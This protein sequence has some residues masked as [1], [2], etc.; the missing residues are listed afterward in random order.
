[1]DEGTRRGM[2]WSQFDMQA[3][4]GGEGNSEALRDYLL[5]HFRAVYS[6]YGVT[7]VEIGLAA[8]T[9]VCIALRRLAKERPDVAQ[10]LF[11]ESDRSP[12]VFQ[13][14]PF[15]H[16]I[17]TNAQRELLFTVTR[18][19]TLLP[20]IRYNPHDEGGVLRDDELRARL[21][22]LDI[23]LDDLLPEGRRRLIRMPYL[24]VFGRKDGTVSVM[25]ANIYPEDIEAAIYTDAAVASRILSWQLSV[26][27]E[28]PGETRPRVAIQF[29]RDD[30]SDDFRAQLATLLTDHL[31]RTN[32]DYREA[33]GEYPALLPVVVD[34][35]RRGE[36]PFEGTE[37]RIKFKYVAKA[38]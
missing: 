24:Y 14:N 23:Q 2:D 17:A 13:Y 12:M 5:R 6:G 25:G 8:E 9:P 20:K 32:R 37:S 10:A 1:M 21:A 29:L 7:D 4:L 15:F 38:P 22:T 31:R 33:F 28:R 34:L 11:G 16:H 35:H 26:L 27:E 19:G 36:G 3:L 18:Q 30:P